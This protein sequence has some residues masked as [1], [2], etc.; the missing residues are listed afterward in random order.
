[1]ALDNE[2]LGQL[3]RTVEKFV[4]ERLRPLES[5]VGTEDRIP[6]EIIQEMRDLG[7]FGLTIPEEYG[8]LG[9]NMSEEVA[10]ARVL[11][12][13][14]PA[15]RPQDDSTLP[16]HR[17]ATDLRPQDDMTAGVGACVLAACVLATRVKGSENAIP[18]IAP[19]VCFGNTFRLL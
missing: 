18:Q 1:M 10:I 6:D 3:L 12:H 16:T 17:C 9:L 4:N 19:F 15:F 13:T 7:L 11:G 14:S 2:T 5:D 8:G